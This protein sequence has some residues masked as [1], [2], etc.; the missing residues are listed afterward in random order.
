MGRITTPLYMPEAVVEGKILEWGNSYGV[1]IRKADLERAGL[2]PG[3]EVLVRIDAT[4]GEVDLSEVRT[5]RS[6][7]AETAA[8]HDEV[9]GDARAQDEDPLA[10]EEDPDGS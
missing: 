5:F 4:D 9:L 6:G 10:D 8:R 7:R 3:Q 2:E 1:R